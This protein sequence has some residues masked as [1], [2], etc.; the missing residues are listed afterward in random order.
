MTIFYYFW[1][2]ALLF[3]L[4]IGSFLNVCVYRIP[5]GMKVYEGRSICPCCRSGLHALDLIPVVSYIILRGKCRHCG[6]HISPIYPIVELLTGLLF[7]AAFYFYG[8]SLQTLLVWVLS[9]VLVV[10]SFIDIHTLEIPDGVSLW[11]AAV[12][13][14]SFFVP[15]LVWWQR[16]LGSLVAAS[17]LLIILLVSKGNAM[18]MGDIKLMAAVGLILGYKLSLFALF[19]ATVFGAVIGLLLIILKKK[20]KRDE[21]PFVPMLSFGILFALFFGNDII[22]WYLSLL[23]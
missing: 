13:I 3:G 9:S 8:L 18:G 11:I 16:L 14:A 12:G 1:P 6:C 20:G 23:F 17:P 7:V 2:I 4:C 22:S 19:S 21:I 10:A 15:D 5:I